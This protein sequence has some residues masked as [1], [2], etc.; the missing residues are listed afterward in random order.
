MYK[1]KSTSPVQESSVLPISNGC[2][3]KNM[4]ENRFRYGFNTAKRECAISKPLHF[5]GL[6]LY[7]TNVIQLNSD[8]DEDKKKINA[9]QCGADPATF[10]Y[11]GE[12][13]KLEMTCNH[14]I[15]IQSLKYFYIL[16]NSCDDEDVKGLFAKW[17]E[18]AAKSSI[19]SS[20]YREKG[21]YDITTDGNKV[22]LNKDSDKN[23]AYAYS[24]CLWMSGNIIIGPLQNHR[25]DDP[26]D[27]FDRVGYPHINDPEY[28]NEFSNNLNQSIIQRLDR[29]ETID[30]KLKYLLADYKAAID[31]IVKSESSAAKKSSP[32]KAAKD[33][34]EEKT[35]PPKAGEGQVEEKTPPPKAGEDQVE[36]KTPP[37]KAEEHLIKED[38]P[39][40]EEESPPVK[41]TP[42][43]EEE[44]PP[45]K[46]TPSPKAADNPQQSASNGYSSRRTRI[47]VNEIDDAD[48][49]KEILLDLIEISQYTGVL[50]LDPDSKIDSDFKIDQSGDPHAQVNSPQPPAYDPKHW[51][52]VGGFKINGMDDK[53]D[54]FQQ[55]FDL[56]NYYSKYFNK[57]ASKDKQKLTTPYIRFIMFCKRHLQKRNPPSSALAITKNVY[58][59]ME[60]LFQELENKPPF[61]NPPT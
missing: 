35:P 50:N 55:M 45:A 20:Q 34:T 6:S 24:S 44:G 2:A 47:T 5:R 41:D 10:N 17:K 4:H 57:N 60:R 22:E 29:L 46:D 18:T 7:N 42:P 12:Q 36:E 48:L 11:K 19:A 58:Y 1:E 43:E 33:P 26:S 37:P 21:D 38:T 27:S 51:F 61:V 49:I 56:Y 52:S 25:I 39:P 13:K 3:R 9:A 54:K 53:A 59:T 32:K 16:C 23:D 30:R 40:K 31:T 8:E 14:I 15:P 28:N